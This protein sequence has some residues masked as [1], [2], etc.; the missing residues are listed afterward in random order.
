MA[1][2]WARREARLVDTVILIGELLVAWGALTMVLSAAYALWQYQ[3]AASET[4]LASTQREAVRLPASLLAAPRFVRTSL[5][6]LPAP[7]L[8]AIAAGA[9][10][11]G[12]VWGLILPLP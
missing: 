6:A 7:L 11:A 5:P 10:L 8:P 2:I 9:V 4:R 12:A 3:P 1:G